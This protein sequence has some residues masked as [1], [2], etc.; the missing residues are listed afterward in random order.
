[1]EANFARAEQKN[2]IAP[3]IKSPVEIF[4][5]LACLAGVVEGEAALA[6]SASRD[7]DTDLSWVQQGVFG[8]KEGRSRESDSTLWS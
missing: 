4:A 2:H 6:A 7:C 3:P 8:S 5:L 1:M